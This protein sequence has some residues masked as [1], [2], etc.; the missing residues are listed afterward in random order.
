MDSALTY[1]STVLRLVVQGKQTT[2]SLPAWHSGSPIE[3]WADT[4]LTQAFLGSEAFQGG[5]GGVSDSELGV[6]TLLGCLHLEGQ[7]LPS[8]WRLVSDWR[9]SGGGAWIL[10]GLRVY[11]SHPLSSIVTQVRL[12]T[13]GLM[14]SH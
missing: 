7:G 11:I 3:I 12:L 14:N 2:G 9:A 5:H 8:G 13:D 1:S 6:F 10:T 4:G